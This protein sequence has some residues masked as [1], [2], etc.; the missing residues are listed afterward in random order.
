[1]KKYILKVTYWDG[2][3]VTRDELYCIDESTKKYI[4]DENIHL[5]WEEKEK[6]VAKALSM[7]YLYNITDDDE[8][9]LTATIPKI[10][11]GAQ[12]GEDEGEIAEAMQFIYNSQK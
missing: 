11:S 10:L 1:M 6:A 9:L 4:V 2:F 7:C 12:N 3:E 8:K 5:P